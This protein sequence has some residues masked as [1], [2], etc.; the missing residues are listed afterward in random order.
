MQNKNLDFK[1][2]LVYLG[3]SADIFHHGHI[4]IITKAKK[5]GRLVIGLLTD[6]AIS[7]KKRIPM[8]NWEQRYQILS[9]ISGVY[10]VV[11][12]DE[13]D[14]SKFAKVQTKNFVHGDDWKF[15]NSYDYKSRSKV[16][17]ILK[18]INCRLVEIL[19]Y[20]KC[21]Q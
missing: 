17:K 9:N 15:K 16:I 18:R 6:K 19:S 21:K 10:K 4:N 2:K 5:F 20:K 12:Q 3:I 11:K 7:E 14:Y 8:L 1:K 13:W